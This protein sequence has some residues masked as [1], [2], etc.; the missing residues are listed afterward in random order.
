MDAGHY[1]ARPDNAIV[2]SLIANCPP[3]AV[4]KFIDKLKLAHEIR[5]NGK[6][7]LKGSAASLVAR[8]EELCKRNGTILYGRQLL[9]IQKNSHFTLYTD[10]G[11]FLTRRILLATGSPA[12]PQK[13]GTST[14][15]QLLKKSGIEIHG[16]EPALT[17]L[18]AQ[19]GNPFVALSGISLTATI[20]LQE[21]NAQRSLTDQLLFTHRGLSG[22]CILRASLYMGENPAIS[23]D[24]LPGHDLRRGL[25]GAE[26]STPSGYLK[27]FLPDRLVGLL[28]D[29]AVAKRRIAELSRRERDQITASFKALKVTDMK[30]GGM[31]LAEVATGG[32]ATCE[33]EP[34]TLELRKIPGIYAAGEIIDVTGSLGGYN[35][36]WA[37]ASAR[38]VCSAL[39]Q[40]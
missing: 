11:A 35:L 5:D 4:I 16:A 27:K 37:F 23:F 38:T 32:I 19:A 22:P 28:L 26:G 9:D 25:D 14:C 3:D 7:F 1:L 31:P 39:N 29:P 17:P 20:T 36:H 24:F 8:L 33:L 34:D 21:G 6:V 18:I 13:G 2:K 12:C 10:R 30:R 15:W 40:G